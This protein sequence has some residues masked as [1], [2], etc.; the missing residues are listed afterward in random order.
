MSRGR[1]AE[2]YAYE[3]KEFARKRLIGKRVKIQFEYARPDMRKDRKEPGEP[4]FYV[5]MFLGKINF[6]VEL[7]H[8]GL[9]NVIRHRRD[10]N[11][12]TFYEDLIGAEG[13]S[14]ATHKGQH[15]KTKYVP[16]R[17]IDLSYKPRK[18]KG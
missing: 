9:A 6:A 10:E 8:A 17:I 7:L 11:R 18:K 1:K 15:S 4:R 3:A 16:R 14:I 12:S 13:K 2:N 5:T